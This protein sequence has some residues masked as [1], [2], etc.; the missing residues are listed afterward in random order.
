MLRVGLTGGLASGKTFV[1]RELAA[2][3]CHVIE[4][5]KIGHAL[6]APDGA[7]FTA[8]VAE[9]GPGILEGGRIDRRAL[10][11]VVFQ[12]AAR[13]EKLNA[14]V[15]PLVIEEEGRLADE[16]ASREPDAI[17]VI[18]AAVMI[19]SGTHTLCEKLIVTVCR[20]EQQIARAVA[21]GGMTEQEARERLA[22]QMPLEEKR[23]FADFIIDTSGTEAETREQTLAILDQIRSAN[24]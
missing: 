15:H 19:E 12:D 8:V 24:R 22:R 11:R 14:I 21:R 20:P 17:V 5:D 4:A 18:E 2:H 23:K 13:L 9:F 7:A 16:I 10:G 6:L 3:G 1:A